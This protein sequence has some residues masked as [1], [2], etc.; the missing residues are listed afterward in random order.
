MSNAASVSPKRP[1][2]HAAIEATAVLAA[3]PD[4]VLVVDL[5]GRL[6]YANAAAEQFFDSS[7]MTLLGMPLV[8]LLPPDSP[9]FALL[10][11]VRDS[12]HSI[13]EYGVTL[14]TPRLGSHILTVQ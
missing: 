11:N 13:S 2:A 10:D 3:L 14:E 8:Q 12:G 4:P 9:V 7:T 6:L 5:S 1:P